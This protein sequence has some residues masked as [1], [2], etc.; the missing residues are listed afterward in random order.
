MKMT[1]LLIALTERGIA[2]PREIICNP[3]FGTLFREVTH[4]E[5]S[6]RNGP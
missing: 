3:D 2:N 1:R 6:S 4:S 5:L